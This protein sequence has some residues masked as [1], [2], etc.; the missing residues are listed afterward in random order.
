[1]T[2]RS[3]M[4][5]PSESPSSAEACLLVLRACSEAKARDV[6]VLDVADLL[7]LTNCFVVASG[8]S[9]RQ[10]QG[11]ANRIIDELGKAGLDPLAVEGLEQ[12]HWVLLDY[13]DVV[14]HVFYEPLRRHYDIEGL[15]AK[16]PRLGEE[17]LPPDRWAA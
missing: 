10:V 7:D 4:P 9:D 15:W 3:R 2:K 8:R 14:V 11:I 6:S 16:A 1:M 17:D 12:G 5:E 13:G